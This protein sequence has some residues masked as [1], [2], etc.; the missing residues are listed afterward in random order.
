MSASRAD[1]VV[2]RL[3]SSIVSGEISAGER[4]PTEAQLGEQFGV[5]R[6]VVR[7]ALQR[8][9][10]AGLTRSKRGSGTFALTPPP[11]LPADGEWL[12]AHSDVERA[13]LHVLRC[14]V[15]AEAAGVAASCTDE[16]SLS[17]LQ[18]AARAFEDATTPAASL[19][20]D[21]AFHLSVARASGNR[22]LVSLLQRV[23]PAAIV[24]PASRLEMHDDPIAEGRHPNAAALEHRAVVAAI[25][26]GDTLAA[27]AAMRTHLSSSLHR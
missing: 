5:S 13:Q 10:A 12:R 25:S 6:T 4:L 14:A 16:A 22:Y 20:A 2:A 15:E 27:A 11:E 18:G 19:E 1:E 3:R 26:A 24:M 8:L 21:F 17:A 9:Q 7:E 23:G